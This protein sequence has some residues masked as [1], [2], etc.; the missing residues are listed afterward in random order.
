MK[1]VL[2]INFN[3][4]WNPHFETELELMH[5][6][7]LEGDNVYSLHCKGELEQMCTSGMFS[8]N[9]KKFCKRCQKQYNLGCK[10]IN[11]PLKNRFCLEEPI[12]YPE[13]VTAEYSSM[14]EVNTI[15]YDGIN[16]GRSILSNLRLVNKREQFDLKI[17]KEDFSILIKNNYKVFSKFKELCTDLEI[18]LVY[19]FNGRHSEYEPLI[20]YCEEHK[21]HFIIHERGAN[22]D[23]YLLFDNIRLYSEEGWP[24]M[25]KKYSADYTSDKKQLAIDWFEGKRRGIDPQWIVFT[26]EQVKAKLPE[27]FDSSKYNITFFNSNLWE[28]LSYPNLLP[29]KCFQDEI[30]TVKDICLT[31]KDN[32]NY[33]FYFR[34]HPHLYH[35]FT[36]QSQKIIDF[37][38][39]NILPNLEVIL[40]EADIDSY[41]LM[42]SSDLVIINQV[43]TVGIESCYWGTPTIL[44]GGSSYKHLDTC[45]CPSSMKELVDL[46]KSKPTKIKN[47]ENC[48]LYGYAISTMGEKFKYYKAINLFEGEFMGIN[49]KNQIKIKNKVKSFLRRML[50]FTL[51]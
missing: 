51:K 17:I 45:Y 35:D 32:P 24:S 16:V 19:I 30:Q 11:L 42:S 38:N 41:Q 4:C 14:N 15:K 29:P 23:R 1:K 26:K 46:L 9:K 43:S 13:Y 25:I 37:K 27:N 20:E 21:I 48:Y 5:Q 28:V 44:L 33:K 49:I 31:F 22:K 2:F 6:H 50:G 40:P 7:Q 18:D 3:C 36:E 8:E 47:Y 12:S 34:T 10:L 39:K